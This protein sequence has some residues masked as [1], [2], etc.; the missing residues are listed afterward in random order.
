MESEEYENSIL[1]WKCLVLVLSPSRAHGDLPSSL[2]VWGS[3]IQPLENE[4]FILCISASLPSAALTGCWN[5]TQGMLHLWWHLTRARLYCFSCGIAFKFPQF[6]WPNTG[7]VSHAPLA[8]GI[9][10]SRAASIP[11]QWAFIGTSLGTEGYPLH[12]LKEEEIFGGNGR[13]RA[14]GR[15]QGSLGMGNSTSLWFLFLCFRMRTTHLACSHPAPLLC[16]IQITQ[17][18]RYSECYIRQIIFV[19]ITRFFS[20]TLSS[21]APWKIFKLIFIF[22]GMRNCISLRMTV[23]FTIN[24]YKWLLQSPTTEPGNLFCFL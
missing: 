10:S 12:C 16:H 13:N 9:C 19:Y 2:R 1:Y 5:H 22:S 24:Q 20:Q 6:S 18:M 7:K 3:V 15:S 4:H 14:Q 21:P 8:N 17:W 23:I 11:L